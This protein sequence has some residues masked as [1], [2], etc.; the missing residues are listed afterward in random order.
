MEVLV[1]LSPGEVS[2]HER[3][4]RDTPRWIASADVDLTV[5]REIEILKS[6]ISDPLGE[7]VVVRVDGSTLL[8]VQPRGT[9]EL[10]VGRVVF[11]SLGY[12]DLGAS[13]WRWVEFQAEWIEQKTPSAPRSVGSLKRGFSD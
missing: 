4:G 12:P 1:E 2:V 13:L 5:F 11:G 7:R 9:G 3:D 6:S 8:D 10:G